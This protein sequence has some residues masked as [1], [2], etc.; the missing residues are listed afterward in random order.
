MTTS[1]AHVHI[2]IALLHSYVLPYFNSLADVAIFNLTMQG[3]QSYFSCTIT[4]CYAAG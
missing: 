4:I 3:L 2:R 1:Y